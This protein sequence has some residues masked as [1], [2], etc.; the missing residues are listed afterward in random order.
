M[1]CVHTPL[2]FSSLSR[3]ALTEQRLPTKSWLRFLPTFT[4]NPDP[5]SPSVDSKA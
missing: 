3:F 1:Y 5:S 2:S 4:I